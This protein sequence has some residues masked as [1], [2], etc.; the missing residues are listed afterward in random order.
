MPRQVVPLLYG[1]GL[2]RATGILAADVRG[3]RDLR[4]VYLYRDKVQVRRGHSLVNTLVDEFLQPLNDVLLVQ[5]L[6]SSQVGVVAGFG[7]DD[8]VHLFQ[9]GGDG[10]GL[11]SIGVA[12]TL[13]AGAHSPPRL[14]AA[15]QYQKLF[16]AHDEPLRT[17]RA[18][19][20]YYDPFGLPALNTLEADLDGDSTPE[21]VLF[22][23]VASYLTYLVGW[24]YGTESDPDHPEVVR[25]SHPDNPTLLDP[26]DYFRAGQGGSPV[27]NCLGAG[28]ASG[29]VLLVLKPTE[30]HQI[31]GYDKRTFGIRLVDASY[32]V[33]ASRLAISLNGVVYT[34][35]LEGPRRSTGGPSID[36]AWPLDLDAPTPADLVEAGALEDGFACYLPGRRCV[37]FVF[38]ARVY[39]LSLW[40]PQTPKWSYSE[41][42]FTAQ[43]GGVLY[44]SGPTPSGPT[45]PPSAVTSVSR[46][47]TDTGFPGGEKL[48]LQ[49]TW[50]DSVPSQWQV[51]VKT[52]ENFDGSSFPIAPPPPI[53]GEPFDQPGNP[54]YLALHA[55]S[56]AT[57]SVVSLG[58]WHGGAFFPLQPV[59]M[60]I[61]VRRTLPSK[62]DWFGFY[63]GTG[64]YADN[65]TYAADGTEIPST[66]ACP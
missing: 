25:V 56:A 9:V 61:Y 62:G 34:W 44:N 50:P 16:V 13:A 31:F 30:T 38:G 39:S 46:C 28:D 15:E 8:R 26:D 22:R 59:K 37:L 10:V 65:K 11:T 64:P 24:G 18:A 32:G 60:A 3:G 40:D 17:L 23:G 42:G 4:N 57:G 41:L 33:A 66:G 58:G 5:A 27:L 12:F 35:S 7:S 53:S 6:Q 47:T 51:W 2:D 45:S 55:F 63:V 54:L 48:V 29:S 1:A 20:V 36:L 52:T 14:T 43:A 21:P 49:P 19:T